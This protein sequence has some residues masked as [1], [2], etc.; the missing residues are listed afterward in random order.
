MSWSLEAAGFARRRASRPRWTGGLLAG[1]LALAGVAGCGWHLRGS[2][3]FPGA[4]KPIAVDGGDLAGPLTDSLEPA[5]VLAGSSQAEPASRLEVL[6]AG[7]D[8]RVLSVDE[9]GRA[10]EYEL[11]YEAR[12]QLTAPGTSDKAQRVLIA[13]QTLGATRTYDYDAG[14]ELSRNEQEDA[15]L[16]SIREDVAQRILFQLQAWKPSGG[17]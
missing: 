12:G 8:R 2:Y 14:A 9:N 4:L 6:E 7:K 15:L 16:E 3:D 13:P 17:G 11:R 5:G 1:V 10:D